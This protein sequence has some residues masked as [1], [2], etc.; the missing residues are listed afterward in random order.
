M[1][2]LDKPV[3]EMTT[4]EIIEHLARLRTRRAQA[5]E[6]RVASK[7]TPADKKSRVKR[8]ETEEAKGAFGAALDDLLMD[9]EP[10]DPK[11]A[12]EA[13][14]DDLTASEEDPARDEETDN[15]DPA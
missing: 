6:R 11:A 2:D 9:D 5:Q 7:M 1:S 13:A 3:T 12:A 8:G 4:E 14:L 10:A 15:G